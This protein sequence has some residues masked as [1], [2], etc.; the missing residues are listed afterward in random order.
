MA[1]IRIT[2]DG[3][4]SESAAQELLT[5]PGLSGKVLE[6]RDAKKTDLLTTVASIITIVGGT[7]T[8]AEQIRQWY[9]EAKQKRPGNFDVLLEG[10][11]G[12]RV[13]LEDATVEEIVQIL[14][15]L[16]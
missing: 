9:Q 13:L 16:R 15:S 4:D 8:I 10:E 11:E 2:I 12:K 14:Q 7:V 6:E 3:E 1:A 5:L